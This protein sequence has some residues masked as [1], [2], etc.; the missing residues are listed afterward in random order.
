MEEARRIVEWVLQPTKPYKKQHTVPRGYLKAWADD[1]DEVGRI[2]R[3]TGEQD[4]TSA[5]KAATMR[6]F[7]TLE[8]WNGEKAYWVERFLGVVEGQALPVLRRVLDTTTLPSE[9][10][11]AGKLAAYLA[12][13]FARGTRNREHFQAMWTW[14][15]EI[16]GEEDAPEPHQNA[17]VLN[18]M[19]TWKEVIDVIGNMR[20]RLVP[21][22][23][24]DFLT[25]DHPFTIVRSRAGGGLVNADSLL[26]PLGPRLLLLM[27]W[28]GRYG[29]RPILLDE[30]GV[31]RVNKHIACYA[32]SW[33]FGPPQHPHY[34]ELRS[35]LPAMPRPTVFMQDGGRVESVRDLMSRRKLL[36]ESSLGSFKDG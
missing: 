17:F 36:G 2:S 14:A 30:A 4:N 13:Q 18:V 26:F 3:L 10:E 27:A 21:T 5:K 22:L 24:A 33:V 9:P 19:D 20:W 16:V 1:R 28:P 29:K 8:H 7:Y 11:E 32:H 34:A 23:A 35:S 12:F 31:L 25:S 15:A 6:E